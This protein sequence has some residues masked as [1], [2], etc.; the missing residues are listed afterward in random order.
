MT[1]RIRKLA[2][3]VESGFGPMRWPPLHW[4]PYGRRWGPL[5]FP[6]LAG[7]FAALVCSCQDGSGRG[8]TVVR[9]WAHQGQEAENRALRQIV[10]EFNATHVE[11]GVRVEITFFPDYQYTEKVSIAAAARDLPD[12]MELDGPTVAQFVDAGLMQSLDSWIAE[13]ARHDFL[14]T[15]L[16]QGTVNGKL[17][18]L[19]AFDSALVLY[20]DKTLLAE[21]GVTPPTGGAAWTWT[22]FLQ[23]CR[24]LKAAGHDPVSLHMDVSADE[25]FTYAF[26]PIVWSAGGRLIAEDGTQV[27]HVLNDKVNVEALRRWQVLFEEDL[28][29]RNPI[30][31]NPFGAGKTAMDWTGHWMARSHMDDKGDRLGVMPL[32]KVGPISAA[33]CGSWCWGITVQAHP[34]KWAAEWVAWVTDGEHGVLPMVRANGAVPA[35]KSVFDADP[36]YQQPPYSVFRA[37]LE[38]SGRPRPRTPHYAPLTQHVAA[39]LRDI[40]SGADVQ[41]RLDRAA[42]Q[43]QRIINRRSGPGA[44]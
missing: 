10:A 31:P 26:S 9:A 25:W 14:P 8:P 29:D 36:A 43:I 7:L 15:I 16:A 23:A 6:A 19:G 22:E 12:A 11:E 28:V 4:F 35:R 21:A 5:L 13:D 2:K 32:P 44:S 41:E 37:L 27:E 24:R 40:A 34:P 1:R 39:A 3:V 42:A 18:A 20:Y 17:Y 33:P 38:S 30:D